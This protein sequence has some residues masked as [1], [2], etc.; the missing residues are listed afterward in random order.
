MKVHNKLFLL[1]YPLGLSLILLGCGGGSSSSNTPTTGTS[2]PTTYKVTGSVPGTLIEAFCKDGSYYSVNSDNNG[3]AKHP[4]SLAL[5]VGVN[6]KFIMTTNE[7][8]VDTTKHIVTPLFFNN[9]TTTSTYFNASADVEIGYV[10]LSLTGAGLQNPITVENTNLKVTTFTNDPLDDDNDGIPNVYEDDDNDGVVNKYDDDDDGDGIVDSKDAD[11]NLDSDGDGIENRYD[12]DDDNDG[13]EDS[14]DTDRDNDGIEDSEDDD[15]DN[16]GIKDA[17]DDDDNNDG[18]KDSDTNNNT[19]T[20]PNVTIPATFKADDGRLLASQCAQCHGTN[21]VSVNSWDSIAGENNL[22]S[23][24]FE[25][26]EEI[27]TAIAHGFTS[28]EVTLMGNWLR[29]L[30]KNNNGQNDDNDRDDD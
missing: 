7:K 15:D 23:E 16:D 22:A 2:T 20:T 13:I 25:D 4:F 3:S 11:N 19:P 1:G 9:G 18:I 24:F 14:K 17:E 6:C 28:S 10:P 27:M 12:V 8:D 29:T 26:E 21:G 5:P 30:S